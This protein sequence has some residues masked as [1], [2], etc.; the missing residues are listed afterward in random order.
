MESPIKIILMRLKL[1][2]NC[3]EFCWEIDNKLDEVL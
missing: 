3:F 2:K 1:P